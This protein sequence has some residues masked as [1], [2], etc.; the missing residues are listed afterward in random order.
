MVMCS[1]SSISV[2]LHCYRKEIRRLLPVIA[3]LGFGFVWS[4]FSWG[5]LGIKDGQS[6][7]DRSSWVIE[8]SVLQNSTA[9]G[10]PWRPM[11]MIC[12]TQLEVGWGLRHM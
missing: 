6:L 12:M 7:F 8:V 5:T 1:I 11:P 4:L 10:C 2:L 9:T 3:V